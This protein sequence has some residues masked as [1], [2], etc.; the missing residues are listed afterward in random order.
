MSE[1]S[2]EYHHGQTPA[3]WAGVGISTVGF[4]V[5]AVSFFLGKE[6]PILWPMFWVSVA[7]VL[8]GALVGGVMRKMGYGQ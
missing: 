8:G 1:S 6:G 3:A 5:M 7:I 4:L 2:K